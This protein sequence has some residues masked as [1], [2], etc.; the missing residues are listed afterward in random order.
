M[1]TPHRDV[2]DDIIW[3]RLS[4]FWTTVYDQSDREAL[5]AIYEGMLRAVD[6]EYVKLTEINLNKSIVT[7]RPLT[8]RRWLRLDMDRYAELRK[9]LRFVSGSAS[10]AATTSPGGLRCSEEGGHPFHF[11]LSFPFEISRDVSIGGV[12]AHTIPLSFPLVAAG[13][14]LWA[15]DGRRLLE[16]SDYSVATDRLS[17]LLRVG[18]V[19]DRFEV[20]AAFDV[21]SDNYRGYRPLA[22]RVSA[23]SSDSV[24]LPL[25]LDSRFPVLVLAITNAPAGSTTQFAASVDAGFATTRRL[26]PY[27]PGSHTS[28]GILRIPGADLGAAT[29]IAIGMERGA[30]NTT[31][32]HHEVASQLT[33]GATSWAVTNPPGATAVHLLEAPIQVFVNGRLLPF[34]AARYVVETGVVEFRDPVPAPGLVGLHTVP[35]EFSAAGTLTSHTHH[36]C[37]AATLE[38]VGTPDVLDDGGTWDDG[39][40]LD[41]LTSRGSITLPTNVDATD[42]LLFAD[43]LLLT[44]GIDYTP[45]GQSIG[46]LTTAGANFALLYTRNTRPFSYSSTD[47]T[48]AYGYF[49]VPDNLQGLLTSF[50]AANRPLVNPTR[51]LIEA[52]N[53]AGSGGN[54][55][56]ALFYDEFYEYEDLPIAAAGLSITPQ[57]ARNIESADTQLVAIPYLVDHVRNPTVLLQSGLDY[58]VVDG[59]LQSSRDLTGTWWCPVVLLDEHILAKN[60]GVLLGDIRDSSEQYRGAL[61][62]NLLLRYSGPTL[63]GLQNAVAAYLG[64]AVVTKSAD[65]V[66]VKS[67]LLGYDVTLGSSAGSQQ[68]IRLLPDAALPSVGSPVF[69]G[70]SLAAPL[71]YDNQ[72]VP[73]ATISPYVVV[74]NTALTELQAGDTVVFSGAETI[75]LRVRATSTQILL[76]GRTTTVQFESWSS[77]VT[78]DRLLISAYR[79]AGA[80]FATVTGTVLSVVSVTQAYLETSEEELDLL[81]GIAVPYRAGDLV[82]PGTAVQPALARVYD[83]QSNPDWHKVR[84]DAPEVSR[85]TVT[86]RPA[87]GYAALLSYPG[88]LQRGDQVL[89]GALR[90]TV[91]SAGTTV[92]L[93]PSVPAAITGLATVIPAAGPPVRIALQQPINTASVAGAQAPATTLQ[94]TSTLGLPPAGRAYCLAAGTSVPLAELEYMGIAAATL[95][96]VRWLAVTGTQVPSAC[97]VQVV[98]EHR[99]YA[100]N[101]ALAMAV[102][103]RTTAASTLGGVPMV[104]PANLDAYYDLVKNTTTVIETSMHD[105][106]AP[107]SQLLVDGTMPSVQTV[108][109]TKLALDDTAAL[110]AS[111]AAVVP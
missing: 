5:T 1:S 15:A 4:R 29:L 20:H 108:L 11:H 12:A 30:W 55:L 98:E 64:S 42:V 56:L 22:V 49:G 99:A 70:A 13:T 92:L 53:I 83:H 40:T 74:F 47:L 80:P 10:T 79:D 89:L 36:A 66:G 17:V 100:I 41:T 61:L 23:A 44:P 97:V 63:G 25:A 96:G 106:S 46:F 86:I 95:T 18:A 78:G 69:A 14:S 104:S 27:T 33:P 84:G 76:T 87:S 19:G 31:H 57:Q 110:S 21:S 32:T 48:G 45:Q 88:Q 109:F 58:D 2:I 52:A 16:G 103:E 68:T 105:A 102:A 107:L 101:P 6:S 91:V 39:G 50:E 77:A 111:D 35:Y 85:V 94:V 34:N 75:G 59:Q 54:A 28:D 38:T 72:L 71:V 67:R 37:Q 9:W 93:S 51:V 90:F 8:Q 60:F 24:A 73:V 65:V 82:E 43:G 26:Y 81:P 7:A 62:A 3:D